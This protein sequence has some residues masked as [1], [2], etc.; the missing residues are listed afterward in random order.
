METMPRISSHTS[1]TTTTVFVALV[2]ALLV[3][4]SQAF[5]SQQ[6]FRHIP[7]FSDRTISSYRSSFAKYNHHQHHDDEN[8]SSRGS[9]SLWTG[10]NVDDVSVYVCKDVHTL[11]SVWIAKISN[12]N[13]VNPNPTQFEPIVS[14]ELQ[15]AKETSHLLQ[16]VRL[17]DTSL[18]S[19]SQ[20]LE[21]YSR[22]ESLGR[23]SI[24]TLD[25][26]RFAATTVGSLLHFIIIDVFVGPDH[27][28][29]GTQLCPEGCFPNAGS[30][31]R[32]WRVSNNR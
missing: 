32:R 9:T 26:F 2:A 30:Y 1:R 24:V 21:G 12:C 23:C 25:P 15:L 10:H 13:N 22:Q 7:T 31:P 19:Q 20:S 18:D 5:H 17:K 3:G 11:I 4:T 8:E 6:T 29:G 28:G 14:I 16:T 27:G